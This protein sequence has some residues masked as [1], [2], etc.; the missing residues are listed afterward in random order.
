M[1]CRTTRCS[2]THRGSWQ[3][4]AHRG[5]R[6]AW[7]T[8]TTLAALFGSLSVASAQ[9][10]KV[11]ATR[12]VRV[13]YLV[14][15]DAVVRPDYTDR[16][17]K[18]IEHL[19]IWYR[20]E[21]G[22]ATTFTLHKP[23]VEVVQSA[24]VTAWYSTN[25]VGDNPDLWFF[26]NVV[27]D[28]FAL[29]GGGFFDPNNIWVFYI[30]SDPACGQLVGAT[31]GVAVLPANDLRGLAGEPNIPPCPGQPPDTAGVCRW[32][33]GLGH[34]LGHAFGLPHPPACDDADPATICPSDTL[35]W[36]GYITYPDTYLLDEDKATLRTSPFFSRLP[37]R[38]SLPDCSDLSDR[39]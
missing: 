7:I 38:R 9:D 15:A 13:I 29:T 32:V 3:S 10:D 39:R 23:V 21:M 12:V 26:F 5:V 8:L 18:A 11:Q 24:Q 20:N 14:P 30:D 19:Q 34:E 27:A 36:L 25:P 22:A 28:A 37:G 31:S 2:H 33:G 4:G 35:L 16:L 6:N 17:T 1:R